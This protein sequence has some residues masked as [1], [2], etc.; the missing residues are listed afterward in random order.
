[1]GTTIS[2]RGA[3]LV[4]VTQSRLVFEGVKPWRRRRRSV[5]QWRGIRGGSGEWPGGRGS[6]RFGLL[7]QRKGQPHRAMLSVHQNRRDRGISGKI[8][9]RAVATA[10]EVGNNIGL[11]QLATPGLIRQ[12]TGLRAG[13]IGARLLDQCGQPF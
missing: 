3:K 13:T 6:D 10:H 8:C 11:T 9:R 2:S 5:G 4:W 1:M 7:L 12:L